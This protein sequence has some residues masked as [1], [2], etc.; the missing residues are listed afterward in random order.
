MMLSNCAILNKVVGLSIIL[1]K[2]RDKNAR[3]RLGLNLLL[4]P[5]AL[6]P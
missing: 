4:I 1:I 6:L 5:V 2:M 3:S